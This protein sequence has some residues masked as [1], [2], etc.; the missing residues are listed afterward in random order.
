[1]NGLD[2]GGILGISLIASA[3]FHPNQLHFNGL[4]G[5]LRVLNRNA[6]GNRCGYTVFTSIQTSCDEEPW[7]GQSLLGAG[8]LLQR[9]WAQ[10]EGHNLEGIL[11]QRHW[12]ILNAELLDSVHGFAQKIS[13]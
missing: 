2:F 5:R 6:A 9:V 12:F 8:I 1:L 11:T 4:D 13:L 3:G 10:T 7:H